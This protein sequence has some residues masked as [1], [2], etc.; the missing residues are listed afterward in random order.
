LALLWVRKSSHWSVGPSSTQA[1]APMESPM[2]S[3]VVLNAGA[4]GDQALAPG[5]SSTPLKVTVP[6]AASLRLNSVK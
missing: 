2:N 3:M 6:A 1:P 5:A 4:G